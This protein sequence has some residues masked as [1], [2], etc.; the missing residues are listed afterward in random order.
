MRRY[1][2]FFIVSYL[3]FPQK[4]NLLSFDNV[5]IRFISLKT[6]LYFPYRILF[7]SQR[8]I[9]WNYTHNPLEHCCIGCFSKTL[10]LSGRVCR[11]LLYVPVSVKATLS[12]EMSSTVLCPPSFQTGRSNSAESYRSRHAWG[13]WELREKGKGKKWERCKGR[14]A[15]SPQVICGPFVKHGERS[16]MA[17]ERA[18]ERETSKDVRTKAA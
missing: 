4:Q 2:D 10:C 7:F 16:S 5:N 11:L 14:K 9:A 18:A 1:N 15:E 17:G 8:Y 13:E 3:R 12:P 6:Y